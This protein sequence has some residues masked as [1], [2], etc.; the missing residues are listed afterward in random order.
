MKGR[1]GVEGCLGGGIRLAGDTD[2]RVDDFE[3]VAF[4]ALMEAK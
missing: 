3:V 2:R 1:G 4:V